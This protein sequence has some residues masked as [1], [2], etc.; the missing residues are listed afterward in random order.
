MRQNGVYMKKRRV[1]IFFDVGFNDVAGMQMY[2]AG[3]VRYLEEKGWEVHVCSAAPLING[4]F[5]IDS[6]TKYLK[7]NGRWDFLK[8]P[9]Y[10]MR[11][12][13]QN[14]ILNFMIEHL[15]LKDYKNCEI[16]IE[17]HLASNA[18]WAELL[19]YRIK[20]RHFTVAQHEDFSVDV[21]MENLD[22]FYFKWKRNEIIAT[23]SFLA[24][25]FNGYKN[26][27]KLL[28]DVPSSVREQDPIIDVEFKDIDKLEV[29]DW[30]ICYFGRTNKIYLPAIIEGIGELAQRYPEKQI[31]F[32]IIGYGLDRL[33]LMKKT[34]NGITNIKVTIFGIMCPV[35][36]IL[37]SKFDVVL[38]GSGSARYAANEG[39][40][41][42][43]ANAEGDNTPGVLGYDTKS[44][45]YGTT[46]KNIT[47]FEAL[48]NVLVKKLYENRNY[49][50]PKV[51]P[52]SYS[53]D[54]FWLVVKNAAQTKEYYNEKL[55][56][57]RIRNW[58]AIFPFG[59]IPKN[60]KI[61][62]YGATEIRNDYI[63]QVENQKYCQVIIT[64]DEN[65]EEFDNSV[66][67]LDRLKKIDYDIIVISTF[68][69]DAQTAY[70]NILKI[71]PQMK[72]RIVYNFQTIN[73]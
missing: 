41:T 4:R 12:S 3:K 22:F 28:I 21:Y 23:N 54:N 71:V 24:R 38:A 52:A 45:L 47:Y 33:E 40:L 13:D 19:A 49:D 73:T 27:N 15:K 5:L 60:S 26:V 18:C 9:P 51:L 57:E 34:F 25:L 55:S 37:F 20:A 2:T 58:I 32:M 43:V 63:K 8:T 29:L 1:F 59:I 36:K 7:A 62:L 61:V 56:Q 50:M 10:K 46:E 68:P 48:E 69:K 16:I 44:T 14:N 67:S 35:P 53:Y 6:L 39:V 11:K 70:E 64:V 17:S 30:N 72:E 31:H 42:I 65:D 66:L